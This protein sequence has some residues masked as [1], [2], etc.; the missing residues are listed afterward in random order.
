MPPPP[1]VVGERHYVSGRLSG[2]P[3]VRFPSVRCWFVNIYFPWCGI[4]ALSGG[5]STK[6]ATNILRV[7][8]ENVFKVRGQRS[9]VKVI[10]M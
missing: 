5:I 6:L 2:C 7:S 4:C 3:Y 8:P 9:K 10:A 1:A